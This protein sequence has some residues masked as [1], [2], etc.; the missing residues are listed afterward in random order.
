MAEEAATAVAEAP[1]PAATPASPAPTPAAPAPEVTAPRPDS[2][3]PDGAEPIAAPPAEGPKEPAA[4][5]AEAKPPAEEAPAEIDYGV[6]DIPDGLEVEPEVFQKAVDIFAENGLS[7]EASQKLIDI[8]AAEILKMQ[9]N[10]FAFQ[11]ETWA[12]VNKQWAGEWKADSQIGAGQFDTSKALAQKMLLDFGGTKEQIEKL[13]GRL[14]L[15]GMGNDVNLARVLVNIGKRL[16]EGRPATASN[17][18][19]AAPVRSDGRR[20]WYK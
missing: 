10:W 14:K 2:P 4:P 6:F 8:S 5:S 18:P 15:T 19:P 9:E 7:K 16:E 3:V 17:T 1:A 20:G 12:E 13:I 11:K